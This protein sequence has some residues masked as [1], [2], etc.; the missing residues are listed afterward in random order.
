M[1]FSSDSVDGKEHSTAVS[2]AAS[3]FFEACSGDA[4]LLQ[5]LAAQTTVEDV[6]ALAHSRGF[7]V[8]TSELR[9]YINVAAVAESEASASGE[10]TD[11][12]L[13]LVAG[14]TG[15]AACQVGATRCSADRRAIQI[16]ATG[17]V[18]VTQPCQSGTVC[19]A[20]SGTMAVCAR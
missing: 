17:G 5:Q 8:S 13:D 16:C 7:A 20:Q 9:Q 6:A 1:A 3:K 19:R 11:A 2:E 10:L 4:A 18:W 12:E 15:G 14:G